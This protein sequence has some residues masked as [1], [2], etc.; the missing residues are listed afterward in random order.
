MRSNNEASGQTSR[1]NDPDD[2]EPVIL[3][4]FFGSGML[5]TNLISTLYAAA[6]D[7]SGKQTT[8]LERGGREALR[9]RHTRLWPWS[10]KAKASMVCQQYRL[11]VEL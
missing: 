6:F 4:E 8:I 10:A 2:R 3:C 5:L 1:K 9:G 11:S 7:V